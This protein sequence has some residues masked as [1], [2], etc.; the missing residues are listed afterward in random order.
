MSTPPAPGRSRSPERRA[1]RT[2]VPVARLEK[3]LVIAQVAREPSPMAA[4]TTVVFSSRPTMAVST[5][6]TIIC[7]ESPATAGR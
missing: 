5:T 6:V 2:W 1:A 3:T 7:K 4:R